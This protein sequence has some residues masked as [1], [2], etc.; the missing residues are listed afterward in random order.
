MTS[1]EPTAR[2][3]R[4]LRGGPRPRLIVRHDE[5]GGITIEDIASGVV[6]SIIGTH[7]LA[8]GPRSLVIEA[9]AREDGQLVMAGPIGGNDRPFSLKDK[10]LVLHTDVDDG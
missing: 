6:I 7:P 3:A 10:V 1:I 8:H 2:P 4:R 9:Y 5:D